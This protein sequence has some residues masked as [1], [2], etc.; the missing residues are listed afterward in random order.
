MKF[1]VINPPKFKSVK[2]ILK[3]AMI[4]QNVDKPED[5]KWIIIKSIV[6]PKHIGMYRAKINKDNSHEN[7]KEKCILL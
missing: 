7:N 3:N 6:T 1:Q 4:Q 2:D 5:L